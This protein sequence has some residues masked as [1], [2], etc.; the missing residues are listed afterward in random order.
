MEAV[1]VKI[2]ARTI[3]VKVMNRTR[4]TKLM[5]RI[6]TIEPVIVPVETVIMLRAEFL[7]RTWKM[8]AFSGST[9]SVFRSGRLAGGVESDF[10]NREMMLG[11]LRL[12]P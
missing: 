1:I 6:M 4:G 9:R 10:Y 12:S 11:E 7:Q 2:N 5:I 3:K 8:V